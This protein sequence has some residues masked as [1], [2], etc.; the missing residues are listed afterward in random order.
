MLGRLRF[1]QGVVL[2]LQSFFRARSHVFLA[3]ERNEAVLA[4]FRA[5]LQACRKADLGPS[6][7]RLREA[8]SNAGDPSSLRICSGRL[9]FIT[10]ALS[11]KSR[12]PACYFVVPLGV[13]VV[14]G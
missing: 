8:T 12:E 5:K 3:A 10:K 11:W 9:R 2:L 7:D 13:V 1:W 6:L 14:R 4:W